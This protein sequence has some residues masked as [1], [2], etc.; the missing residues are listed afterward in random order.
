MV[1]EDPPGS[2]STGLVEFRPATGSSRHAP[3]THIDFAEFVTE[4]ELSR[5]LREN[6]AVVTVVLAAREERQR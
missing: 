4:E 2:V 3:I 6:L 5:L 1:I